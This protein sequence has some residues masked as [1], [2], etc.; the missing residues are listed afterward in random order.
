MSYWSDEKNPSL[1][2]DE[3]YQ[4]DFVRSTKRLDYD[5]NEF[6]IHKVIS[7]NIEISFMNRFNLD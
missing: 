6:K 1:K 4:I 5:I 2:I 3:N 7:Q